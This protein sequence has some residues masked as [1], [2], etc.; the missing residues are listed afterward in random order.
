MLSTFC[1]TVLGWIFFRA[2]DISHAINYISE[3]FSPSLFK[4]PYF[5]SGS[6][7]IP[8]IIL[9]FYFLTIEW[10]GREG[11]YAISTIGLN[12]RR[13]FRIFFYLSIV[14]MI[15]SWGGSNEEFIYFQ[16]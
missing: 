7:S 8:T 14:F 11:D 5:A 6:L 3:I 4:I 16:F 9:T 15:L 2:E 10:I 12:W 13:S 1:L